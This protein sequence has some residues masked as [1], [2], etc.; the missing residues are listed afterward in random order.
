MSLI[1]TKKNGKKVANLLLLIIRIIRLIRFIF[2]QVQASLG[3]FLANRSLNADIF[4]QIKI[5]YIIN[6]GFMCIRSQ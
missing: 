5:C 6:S 2:E 3:C 1:K 4:P